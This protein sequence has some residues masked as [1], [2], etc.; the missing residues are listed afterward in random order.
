MSDLDDLIAFNQAEEAAKGRFDPTTASSED[1][2]SF[3][4]GEPLDLEAQARALKAARDAR[5]YQDFY[6]LAEEQAVARGYDPETKTWV[7]SA[8]SA[9]EDLAAPMPPSEWTVGPDG[10]PVLSHAVSPERW[11]AFKEH[12]S[13]FSPDRMS[14]QAFDQ[15]LQARAEG[16]SWV[17][18]PE[19]E[20]AEAV[21]DTFVQHLFGERVG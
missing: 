14:D 15:V 16:R 21:N 6:D 12:E 10:L 9:P 5:D 7:R 13:A 17:T 19:P 11:A 1:M 18:R 4:T 8:P 3:V 2:A 20:D